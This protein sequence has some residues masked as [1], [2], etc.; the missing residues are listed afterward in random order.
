MS[1]SHARS[2]D[3]AG[4][5]RAMAKHRQAVAEGIRTL[6]SPVALPKPEASQSQCGIEA[7]HTSFREAARRLATDPEELAKI[8]AR[9]F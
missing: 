7:W 6:A 8:E 5:A 9:I 2:P 4:Q 3:I 1:S